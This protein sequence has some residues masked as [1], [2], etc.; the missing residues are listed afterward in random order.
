MLRIENLT[1]AH[2]HG[3][4]GEESY[5]GDIDSE[6]LAALAG[7]F[8]T[9]LV[10]PNTKPPLVDEETLDLKIREAESQANCLVGFYAGATTSNSKSVP[11]ISDKVCALKIY[12]NN[13]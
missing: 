9:I 11:E 3:R 13:T 10:M 5:K 6:T 8:T 2:V 4:G 1:D 12:M 7:G